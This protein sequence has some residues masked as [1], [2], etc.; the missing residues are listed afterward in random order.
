M[1][2]V[3]SSFRIQYGET[4]GKGNRKGEETTDAAGNSHKD[5]HRI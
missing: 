2:Q 4:T 3:D 5:G 1:I